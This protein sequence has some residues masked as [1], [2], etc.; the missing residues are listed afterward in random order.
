MVKGVVLSLLALLLCPLAAAERPAPGLDEVLARHYQAS[1]G[2]EKLRALK[3]CKL[4][5]TITLDGDDLAMPLV[6]WRKRPD[7]LRVETTLAGQTSIQAFDGRRAWWLVPALAPEAQAMPPERERFFRRQAR[8]ADPLVFWKEQGSRL[9]LLDGEAG[10]A[11]LSQ[12]LKLTEPGG[13]EILFFIDAASGLLRA[14]AEP[15]GAGKEREA[16]EVLYGDYRPVDGLQLPFTIEN[17]AAGR[18]RVRIVL[19]AV[20]VDPELPESLFAMPAGGEPPRDARPGKPAKKAKP[21][22]K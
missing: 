8:F 19:N 6:V 7:R 11:G 10:A 18:T 4:T 2:L 14:S 17:R 9:E 21:K 13:R 5:G 16:A 3:G 20:Q 15:G 12:A 1:G 22:K